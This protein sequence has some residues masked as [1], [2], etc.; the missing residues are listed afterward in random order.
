MARIRTIK[1]GFFRHYDLYMAEKETGLPLRIAYAG[2]WTEADREGRFKWSP[3]ELKLGCLPY[4]EVDFSRVLDALRTRGFIVKYASQGRDYGCIP[5]FVDHQIINNRESPSVLPEPNENNILTCEPRVDDACI[6]R[7]Q[8]KGREGKG[9][10]RKPREPRD[11]FDASQIELD[12]LINKT[13]WLEWVAFRKK[14]NKAI[15]EDAARKQLTMLIRHDQG[16]Q[17]RIIDKS[18]QNDWQGLFEPDN[19]DPPGHVVNLAEAN[20]RKPLLTDS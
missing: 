9:R 7:L 2:L 15:S 4:D 16:A 11:A 8:G 6:T 13:S 1:P 18:I 5:S 3:H 19:H 17:A 20:K 10:E 12:P 14:R